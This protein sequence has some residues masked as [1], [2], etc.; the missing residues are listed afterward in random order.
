MSQNVNC[1]TYTVLI[2]LEA[3]VERNVNLPILQS[4][5]II[6]IQFHDLTL[7]NLSLK[8]EVLND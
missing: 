1:S 2:R 7:E 5:N 3:D 6:M 4:H 8:L